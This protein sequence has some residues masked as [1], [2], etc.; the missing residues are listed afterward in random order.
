MFAR[1]TLSLA[2]LLTVVLDRFKAKI[3][4]RKYTPRHVDPDDANVWK[5]RLQDG[6]R[7]FEARAR[8][9]NIIEKTYHAWRRIDC[10]FVNPI[11]LRQ[12]LWAW[13]IP[14]MSGDFARCV[15]DQ[16]IS[17]IAGFDSSQ[18][19]QD[20]L[21]PVVIAQVVSGFGRRHGDHGCLID[22]PIRQRGR[23]GCAGIFDRALLVDPVGLA[24][25][26]DAFLEIKDQLIHRAITVTLPRAIIAEIDAL[27]LRM[28]VV[29][30]RPRQ[31]IDFT[32]TRREDGL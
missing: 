30:I 25:P 6:L 31:V 4:R 27:I 5:V 14:I 17:N 12:R 28:Q 32:E 11:A 2:K 10:A 9:E 7:G 29:V 20:A 21:H 1:S 23:K 3:L 22:K 8:Y 18:A 15:L 16:Q 24:A 13:P 19:V 26:I